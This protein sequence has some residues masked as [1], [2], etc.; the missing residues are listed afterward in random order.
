MT[1]PLLVGLTGGIGSGKSAVSKIFRSLG[2]DIVDADQVSR[3]VVKPGT[4]ALAKIAE[5]F[6]KNLLSEDGSLNR[7]KLREVV[8]ENPQERQW[9]EK[10]LHPLIREMLQTRLKQASS[11]Y[12]ILE[13]PLLVEMKQDSQVNKVIV[14][15]VPV[16]TQIERYLARDGGTEELAKSII[17]TQTSREVRLNAA[18]YVIENT[19]TLDELE[20]KVKNLHNTLMKLSEASHHD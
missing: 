12:A 9:L 17:E 14:I 13:S 15:D 19:G 3:E 6:G 4:P 18:D 2:I 5:H 7:R 10:L 20:E 16:A 1:R 11:P 8:F